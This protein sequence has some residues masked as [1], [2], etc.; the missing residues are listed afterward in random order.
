MF[1][2][3]D[4]VL[5]RA[6][7]CKCFDVSLFPPSLAQGSGTGFGCAVLVSRAT[8]LVLAYLAETVSKANPLKG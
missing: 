8:G 7:E 6:L 4:P 5:L 1:G 3:R 2:F